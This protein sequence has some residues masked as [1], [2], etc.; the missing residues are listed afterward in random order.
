M[1]CAADTLVVAAAGTTDEAAMALACRRMVGEP[2]P[3]RMLSV[4]RSLCFLCG[5]SP[6]AA[7]GRRLSA[8]AGCEAVAYCGERCAAADWCG[9]HHR[10]CGLAA[11]RTHAATRMQSLPALQLRHPQR[12]IV[13]LTDK[14]FSLKSPIRPQRAAKGRWA[15]EL[16]EQLLLL[17]TLLATNTHVATGTYLVSG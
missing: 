1:L 17:P 7:G 13:E 9:E 11:P 8:C 12:G 6:L 14:A 2:V 5:A 3:P 15:P 16:I 4:A 10:E